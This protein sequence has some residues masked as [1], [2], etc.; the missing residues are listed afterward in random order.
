MV[1]TKL[2]VEHT[3]V[4]QAVSVW[5]VAA[6]GRRASSPAAKARAPFRPPPTRQRS[7]KGLAPRSLCLSQQQRCGCEVLVPCWRPSQRNVWDTA[8]KE[9][10]ARTMESQHHRTSSLADAY[11][12]D[13]YLYYDDSH[14]TPSEHQSATSTALAR[15][16]SPARGKTTPPPLPPTAAAIP[17]VHSAQHSTQ[18]P[19][20]HQQA[21]SSS[22][23]PIS[24]PSFSAFRKAVPS[25]VRLPDAAFHT[26]SQPSPS[27]R[28][29]SFSLA[30]QS[31]PRLAEP[32]LRPQSLDSP[33]LPH[34]PAAGFASGRIPHIQA[35]AA[36][37]RDSNTHDR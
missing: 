7:R 26:P 4:Q 22:L 8:V 15:D 34:Q 21:S 14:D 37:P 5:T 3:H 19:R 32:V 35:E 29:A 9:T 23:A 18:Q 33:L 2:P 12:D 10:S 31:S 24:V 20:L 13:Y 1:C 6:G 30:E 27:P 25:A 17:S 28:A 36:H 11:D 16:T